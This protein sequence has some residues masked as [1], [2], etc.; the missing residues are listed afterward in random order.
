MG[1]A[2]EAIA[3]FLSNNDMLVYMVIFDKK[4]VT[5]GNKLF[6]DIE[7]YIDDNYVE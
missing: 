7:Q 3:E 6:S 5:L 4:A 2:L 1:V